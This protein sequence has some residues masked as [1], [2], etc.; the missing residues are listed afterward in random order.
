MRHVC[1]EGPEAGVYYRGRITNSNVIELPEY[2]RSLVD[3]E[4]ISVSLTQINTSQDLIVGG[5]GG[6]PELKLN[7]VMEQVLIVTILSMQSARMVRD[8][9]LNMKE[10]IIQGMI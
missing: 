2:W 3:P 7:R 5:I 9:S 1:L 10:K 8:L 6:A 4:T